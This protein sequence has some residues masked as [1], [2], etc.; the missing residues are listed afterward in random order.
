MTN[1][2]TSTERLTSAIDVIL[3]TLNDPV[4]YQ[5]R[6]GK[7]RIWN[8]LGFVQ[9]KVL[10]GALNELHRGLDYNENVRSPKLK[11]QYIAARDADTKTEITRNE[12]LDAQRKKHELDDQVLAMQEIIGV[13]ENKWEQ[14]TGKSLVYRR[15]NA[16]MAAKPVSDKDLEQIEAAGDELFGL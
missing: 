6:T 8:R 4:P 14:V 16:D 12:M 5:D 11:A 15:R 1:K 10:Y 2:P 7:E 13:L 3:D 9:G